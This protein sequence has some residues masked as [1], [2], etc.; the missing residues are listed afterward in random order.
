M[1]HDPELGSAEE[2][3]TNKEKE[4]TRYRRTKKRT[5]RG[6]N[7]DVGNKVYIDFMPAIYLHCPGSHESCGVLYVYYIC[8]SRRQC[9]AGTQ[10]GISPTPG[11]KAAQ[12]KST[13]KYKE[14]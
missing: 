10:R 11:R 5:K 3:G 8:F 6:R 9:T 14:E 7:K 12:R 1:C 2:R 4:E 13:E